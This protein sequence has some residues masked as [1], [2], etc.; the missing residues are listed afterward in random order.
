MNKQELMKEFIE[1]CK[2]TKMKTESFIN[3]SMTTCVTKYKFKNSFIYEI[4]TIN[5]Y[6]ITDSLSE[7]ML[8]I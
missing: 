7:A 4:E 3:D 5:D 6:K 8:Y 2:K 1:F